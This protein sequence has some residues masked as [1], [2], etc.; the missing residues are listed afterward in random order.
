MQLIHS[1]D[2]FKGLNSIYGFHN[3]SDSFFLKITVYDPAHVKQLRELLW[4]GLIS[5]YR[6]QS[7]EAHIDY[8]MH[9][10][11]DCDL[12]GMEFIKLTDFQFR[13]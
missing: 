7:Y 12:Y 5:S 4:S 3:E 10:Y 6:F 11:T 2:I 13:K 9:F 1:I 8:S